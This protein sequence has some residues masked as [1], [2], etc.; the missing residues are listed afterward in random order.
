MILFFST[1][2]GACLKTISSIAEMTPVVGVEIPLVYPIEDDDIVTKFM[3]MIL[4][5]KAEGKTVKLAM[6]D[7][8]LTFPG[9]RMPWEKLVLVCKMFNVLSLI[10][11]AHG[12]GHIVLRHLGSVGPDFFVSNCH[13]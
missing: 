10:D 7:T 4:R 11:G 1:I 3:E 12:I 9:A 5:V 13:K 2:Y 6:F 8:V